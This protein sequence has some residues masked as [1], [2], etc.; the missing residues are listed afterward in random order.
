M[1]KWFSPVLGHD[2]ELKVYGYYGKPVLVF[3]SQ[4]G[5]FYDFEDRGMVDAIAGFIEAGQ[6]KLFSVDSLDGQSWANW[7]AHPADRARRHQDYDRY[8]VEEVVSFM[9]KHCGDTKQKFMTTGVSM[10]AYH[11]VNFFFRHPDIFDTVI[12]LS[13]LYQLSMFIGDYMDDNVYFNTPLAYLRNLEDHRYLDQ[14]RRSRIIIAVGQGAWED[15]MLADTLARTAGTT[16][17]AKTRRSWRQRPTLSVGAGARPSVEQ[18]LQGYPDIASNDEALL[19]LI[20]TEYVVREELGERPGVDEYV[21]RFPQQSERLQRLLS[22]DRA[23]G[24]ARTDVTR[25]LDTAPDPSKLSEFSASIAAQAAAAAIEKSLAAFI[26]EEN[27]I[28]Q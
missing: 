2:M 6:V 24:E 12:A 21:R 11:A 18:F 5:R 14:Y 27:R 22:L 4:Q 8:I 10:G 9:R 7:D 1:P 26:R 16:S 20:Y 23:L 13:G 3:P 15:D 19:D 28:D 25:S 17:S